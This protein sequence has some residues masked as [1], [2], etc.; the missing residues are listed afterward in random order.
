MKSKLILAMLTVA[1]AATFGVAAAEDAVQ[2]H[3]HMA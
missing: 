1:L 3:S 2:A